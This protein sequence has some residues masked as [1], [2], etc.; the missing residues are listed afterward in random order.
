MLGA[1]GAWHMK[2][3]VHE[4]FVNLNS[5]SCPRYQRSNSKRPQGHHWC[6]WKKLVSWQINHRIDNEIAHFIDSTRKRTFCLGETVFDDPI[7]FTEHTRKV[8]DKNH[9]EHETFSFVLAFLR[10]SSCVSDVNYYWCYRW[11]VSGNGKQINRILMRNAHRPD[12]RWPFFDKFMVA[13]K[14]WLIFFHCISAVVKQQRKN[15]YTTLTKTQFPISFDFVMGGLRL[16]PG[17][18]HTR[19]RHLIIFMSLKG[20]TV[21]VRCGRHIRQDNRSTN[22][23]SKLWNG[24]GEI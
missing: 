24:L 1:R 5:N 20:M 22:C 4:S 13:R 12:V 23:I 10:A 21:C 6:S 19:A 11:A 3:F 8:N 9:I 18:P 7:T 17:Q 2:C 14:C 15:T 16:R